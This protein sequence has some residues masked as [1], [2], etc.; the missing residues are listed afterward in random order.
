METF[1]IDRHAADLERDG[2]TIL[3]DVMSPL[4]RDATREVIEETLAAEETIS[5]KYGLQNEDLRMAFNAQAKHP[6]FYGILLRNPAPIEVARRVLGEDMFA[7]DLAIRAPMPT[8]KKDTTRL[9]GHLH[10]DWEDFTVRPF[11][12]GK[13]YPLAI[14]SAWAIVD[15]TKET[16]GPMIWPGSHLSNEI[17]PEQPE[18]LPPGG[19]IAEALAGSVVMWDSSLWHTGGI[20]YSDSPRYSLIFFFQRW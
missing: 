3:Y 16:G 19:I 17:P 1:D 7:H 13:H 5:R 4:E 14:Q 15:F 18:T 20:N 10:A 8:G 6:H 12:G 9:G 11:I 2:Y